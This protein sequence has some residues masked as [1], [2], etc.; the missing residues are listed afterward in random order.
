VKRALCPE[1]GKPMRYSR[2]M[3]AWDCGAPD[4]GGHGYWD[5]ELQTLDYVEVQ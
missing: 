4:D 5:P 1:C 3:H 2:Q